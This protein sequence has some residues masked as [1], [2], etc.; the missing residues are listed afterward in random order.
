MNLPEY[1][2]DDRDEDLL[3]A[4][5]KLTYHLKREKGEKL[6][7]YFGRWDECLRKVQEHAVELP[8]KYKGFLMINSLGLDDQEIRS[9]LNFTRGSIATKDVKD[10]IRKNAT[11]LLIREVGVDSKT[12]KT[13]S[14]H[15]IDQKDDEE[16]NY[17]SEDDTEEILQT[18]LEEL[19]PGGEHGDPGFPGEG[20][21]VYEEHEMA[22]ILSTMIQ[23]QQKKRTFTQSMR[24]KKQKELGRGFSKGYGKGF[25]G[26]KSGKPT[27]DALKRVTRCGNCQKIGN[28]HRECPEPDRRGGKGNGAYGQKEAMLVE[29]DRD[30][31]EAFFCGFLQPEI[32]VAEPERILADENLDGQ[33]IQKSDHHQ[34]HGGNWATKLEMTSTSSTEPGLVKEFLMAGDSPG[35]VSVDRTAG[36]DPDFSAGSPYK[37]QADVGVFVEENDCMESE[38]FWD[39]IMH[40]SN[41][42]FCT[43]KQT[44][45]KNPNHVNEEFCATVDTGCQ[46]MAIGASTLTR[47]A[48][49]LP[50]ELQIGMIPQEHRFRSVHGTSRTSHLAAIP[51]SLGKQG[52]MLRPAIFQEEASKDA[53]FLISLPFMLHCRT[54]LYLDP[55]RGLRL[56]FRKF[57]YGVDCH[58][59]PTGALRVPLNQFTSVQLEKLKHLQGQ[60]SHQKE[61]E[62][63]KT[64]SSSVGSEGFAGNRS[65]ETLARDP[66]EALQDRREVLGCLGS[67]HREDPL[68]DLQGEHDRGELDREGQC[69]DSRG[70]VHGRD[71]GC[72]LDDRGWEKPLQRDL[73]ASGTR[74]TKGI[75]V[76]DSRASDGSGGRP[77]WPHPGG[78]AEDRKSTNLSTWNN[79]QVM[80]VQKARTQFGSD[81]LEVPK[82][83][84]STMRRVPMDSISTQV[85]G[86]SRGH[87][88]DSSGSAIPAE[89]INILSNDIP[90]CIKLGDASITTDSQ[91]SLEEP[92]RRTEEQHGEP[93]E[94]P[95]DR[96]SMPSREDNHQR[97]QRLCQSR[98][99]FEMSQGSQDNTAEV[100][101]GQEQSSGQTNPRGGER[102][103]RARRVQ[104]IHG[105]SKMVEGEEEGSQERTLMQQRDPEALREA[106]HGNRRQRRTIRQVLFKA[107][108]ALECSEKVMSEIMSLLKEDAS[109][110][111]ASKTIQQFAEDKKRLRQL[112]RLTQLHPKQVKLVAE[113]YNPQ[114]FQKK[115]HEHDLLPGEAFD[116]E[117]GDDLLRPEVQHYVISYLKVV[118]PGLVVI[119][120]PCTLFS[121]LQNLNKSR[122]QDPQKLKAHM[123]ELKRAKALLKFAVKVIQVVR[124]YDG[125][126][127]F[128]HPLTSRAWQEK[129]IQEILQEGDVR[130]AVSDQC[131]FGLK[132]EDGELHRK[133]TGWMTNSQE[134]ATALEKRCD[135]THHH[136]PLLGNCPKSRMNRTRR[137]QE[138][139]PL[140]VK[141]I[142]KAY[143]EKVK[144]IDL[145]YV[146]HITETEI[147]WTSME[148]LKEG[149]HKVNFLEN[150]F[151]EIMTVDGDMGTKQD[152]EDRK[153][154]PQQERGQPSEDLLPAEEPRVDREK[155]GDLHAPEE[156]LLRELPQPA[157]GLRPDRDDPV[158]E[159]AIPGD[160]A[161]RTTRPLPREKPLS[162]SHLVRRAHEGLG[163]PGNERLARIL[164]G[165]GATEEAVKLAKNLECSV[166]QQHQLTKPPR[167]AAPPKEL[168][169][170]HTVGVDT[171]YIPNHKGKNRMA[172]N[173]VDW[174][175][176]FQM[177]IP[178]RNHTPGE[179]RHAYLQWVR[180]FGPPVRL[181]TDLGKE[182][183][184]AF[185]E[186]ASMDDTLIEPGALE[187]PTQRSITERAGKSFK[188]IFEKAMKDYACQNEDEWKDLV[189]VTAMTMNRLLNAGYSP[190]QRVLG[191]TPRVPGGVRMENQA[192]RRLQTWAQHGDL[193]MQKAQ[194]MRLAAAK[195]F[196]EADC[197]QAISNA[198]HA[199]PRP[200][201]NFEAGQ[202]VYFWR[203]A[204]AG[205]SK[206]APKYWQGPARVVLT[207]PPNAVYITFRAHIVKAAPEHLRHASQEEHCSLSQWM[208]DLSNLRHELVREPTAG[209][210]DL[211]KINGD[212][213]P[214]ED[215]QEPL[216]EDPVQPKFRLG[217][218]TPLKQ[219]I[220]RNTEFED[221]W[222]F[223][224]GDTL[225]RVHVNPRRRTFKPGEAGDCPVPEDQLVDGEPHAE[226]LW[227]PR[228]SSLRQKNGK[229]R[230]LWRRRKNGQ[231]TLNS[232][233]SRTTSQKAPE[234]QVRDIQEEV[235]LKT[236]K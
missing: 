153:E 168:P 229:K 184:G 5:S 235:K 53:P 167:A 158:G 164:K 226:S 220:P 92:S 56:F 73:G 234:R 198:L 83:S 204:Q 202:T 102:G 97:E 22:E 196:H 26:K 145:D 37:V 81:V 208:D 174:S 140:L 23:Q 146:D 173:I 188:T 139:P 175:S 191:Y 172:L 199:G 35:E 67:H 94:G 222:E 8:D 74:R 43:G 18:A 19:Q 64:C 34:E 7:S 101:R 182:F 49:H 207:A 6:R 41:K 113:I 111:K 218:K 14:V 60:I 177:V 121:I 16:N 213:L 27:L 12:K 119:S 157:T 55:E 88:E 85:E 205:V 228:K 115:T 215:L 108:K 187:M 186:G 59:G 54:V 227:V 40:V 112:E 57:G 194:T 62:I 91:R 162:L 178:L 105:V 169:V 21:D 93:A 3:G 231:D 106:I 89:S 150:D 30:H 2:G 232:R 148:N 142:L 122:L 4:L 44:P 99:L 100:V 170:N 118:K 32:E 206:N 144:K 13:S 217:T 195:A 236:N 110:Q 176:R 71:G 90:Q 141:T 200:E 52:S 38:N 98:D 51:T 135:K 230:C 147:N 123:M 33:P 137:A 225:R 179:A 87:L 192:D 161:R 84:C 216:P 96:S 138:Y 95:E 116:L 77:L 78:D 79:M 130:M 181:Y 159:N 160:E 233:S 45:V 17:E 212:D 223:T 36:R 210:I 171:I 126:F 75:R 11:K 86:R 190:I 29:L 149:Y 143:S 107:D 72:M 9:M 125:I 1:F 103:T 61:Y 65:E 136:T 151:Q 203:K 209:Y 46:R 197:K 211:T 39:E 128:E 193:Q 80:D 28:W 165:A 201:Q 42:P 10:W 132:D 166:C 156:P 68:H 104:A 120:P 47:L 117:L 133:S 25:K 163:H 48:K 82:D 50:E 214:P 221:N 189:D 15:Y 31:E 63:L 109:E 114:R 183:R 24:L 185:Q 131:M 219:V 154:V 69:R 155:T 134:L 58:I 124:G 66:H 152:V 180:F 20:D 76:E 129:S 224:A 70:R 127:L